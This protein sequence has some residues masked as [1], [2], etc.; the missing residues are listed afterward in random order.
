[1]YNRIL[2]TGGTALVG[3]ALKALQ[4]DYPDATFIFAGSNDCDLRDRNDA[5]RFIQECKPDAI[6]HL[7]AVSG[8]VG[9]STRHP[10]TLMRDNILMNLNVLESASV[11]NLKKTIMTLSSGMYPANAINPLK[12]EYIHEGYP[13]VSNYGYSFAKRLIDPA[14]KAYRTEYGLNV[15]GL[16]PNGIFGEN[17]NFNYEDAPMLP[18]LIRRFYEN[19]YGDSKIT[20]WG[21]GG[22]LRE[23]TYSKDIARAYMWCLY[24]YESEQILNIGTT[25]EHSVKEIAFMVA[26][27]LNINRN[28]L[29]FDI[30]K[31][32]G[33]YRKSTDNS[34]FV[35]LSNFQY[36][37]F[38]T[39]L[40]NTIKWFCNAYENER[41]SL[42]LSS[43]VNI[44]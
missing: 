40:E 30:S 29:E 27:I 41:R 10:A 44:Y 8:G 32:S 6:I 18:S 12:E 2:V 14:I 24:N 35:N 19:R 43:K 38:K 16:I 15:I 34:R 11:F 39:G 7:A 26:D 37:P 21:D 20:I 36:T 31:P 22:P 5:L 42:R 28:Q 13:H 33:I 25:E 9:L 17:D 23:Y 4:N 3:T 1:M